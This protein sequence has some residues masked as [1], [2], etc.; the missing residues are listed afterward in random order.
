MCVTRAHTT[1]LWMGSMRADFQNTVILLPGWA[2]DSRV[3][4]TEGIK[5]NILTLDCADPFAIEQTL[6][7]LLEKHALSRVTL[8][9]YSMGGFAAAAFAKAHPERVA[10]LVLCGIRRRYLP[11]QIAFV[12]KQIVADKDAY[13][14]AFYSQAFADAAARAEFDATLRDDYLRLFSCDD[15]DRGL[16][17][18]A[19]AAIECDALKDIPTTSVHGRLDTIAPLAEAEAIAAESGARICV[20]DDVGHMV[21][22]E[23]AIEVTL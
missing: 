5:E 10:S 20:Y 7:A 15:L 12:K 4:R 17:Y 18:L 2:T 8:V 16:D 6:L 1:R 14:R 21:V 19:Q 3:F 22:R 13:L 11:K 9:G 23:R